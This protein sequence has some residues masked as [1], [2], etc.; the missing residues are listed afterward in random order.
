MAGLWEFPGGKVEA[1]ET[2]EMALHRG[3]S[4]G[5]G[6]GFDSGESLL[7]LGARLHQIQGG[8]ALF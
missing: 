4:R 5:T 1:G 6:G 8:S 3:N 7:R 2:P